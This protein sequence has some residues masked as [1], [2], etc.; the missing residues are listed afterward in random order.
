MQTQTSDD[1]TPDAEIE[2]GISA[3]ETEVQVTEEAAGEIS[4]ETDRDNL[5]ADDIEEVLEAEAVEEAD[6]EEAPTRRPVPPSSFEATEVVRMPVKSGKPQLNIVIIGV[7]AVLLAVGIIVLLSGS[8]E[9][10]KAEEAVAGDQTSEEAA[11][12]DKDKETEKDKTKE[13]ESQEKKDEDKGEK[14]VAGKCKPFSD[15]PKFPWREQIDSLVKAE[16]AAGICGVFGI[17]TEK[18]A[19]AFDGVPQYGPTGYD[20]IPKG[21]LFEIFPKGKAVRRQPTVEFLFYDDKLFEIRLKYGHLA[22]AD[23]PDNLFDSLLAGSKE[24]GAD[25]QGRE[26]VRFLDGDVIVEQLRK[27][28]RYKRSF[29]E[30]VFASSGVRADIKDVDERRGKAEAAFA[31]GMDFFNVRKSRKAI[32]NF[33]KARKTVPNVG[34]AYVWEGIT[35]VRDEGFKKADELATKAIEVSQDKRVHAE[36]K[37]LRGVAALFRGKKEEATSLFRS[38]SELDPLNA[39]FANSVYELETGKYRPERVAKTAA[40]MSCMGKKKGRKKLNK[41]TTKGLLARGN[42][43]SEKKYKKVL[44]KAQRK[45]VFKKEKKRWTDWECR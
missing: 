21:K 38:A 11:S 18:V 16:S 40:R 25:Y 3:P 22:A 37:G 5:S 44:K 19:K 13:K 14:K 32:S 27:T 6:Q 34:K 15:Y 12:V 7:V 2:Q 24:V 23:M 41:W 31:K 10:D 8:D 36:A 20:L 33:Q 35:L 43:P 1:Q 42:F 30:L 4:Q 45:S 28:D 17:S 39:E 9:E 29:R 26:L